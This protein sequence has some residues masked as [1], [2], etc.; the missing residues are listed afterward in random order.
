MDPKSVPEIRDAIALLE[1]YENS[2]LSEDDAKRFACAMEMLHDYLFDEPNTPHKEFIQ[3]LRVTH[4]HQMMKRISSV[5]HADAGASIQ[6]IRLVV[7]TVKGEAEPIMESDPELE[8]DFLALLRVW[9]E[10]IVLE[11]A[12]KERRKQERKPE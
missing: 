4:T 1:E 11:L 3:H 12:K 5:N 2:R 8:K 10:P 9:A 6:H 7:D